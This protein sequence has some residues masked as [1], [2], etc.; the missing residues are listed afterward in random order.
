MN[1]IIRQNKEGK[2]IEISDYAYIAICMHQA[3]NPEIFES[4]KNLITG[5]FLDAAYGIAQE[6]GV[7]EEFVDNLKEF[8]YKG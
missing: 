6:F 8:G 7:M 1:K 2:E 3:L 5:D 4:S